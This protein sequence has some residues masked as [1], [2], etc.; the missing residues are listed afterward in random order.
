MFH[1]FISKKYGLTGLAVL[2]SYGT[3][4]TLQSERSIYNYKIVNNWIS[5]NKLKTNFLR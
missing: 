3:Y 2:G 4:K 1:R 5:L